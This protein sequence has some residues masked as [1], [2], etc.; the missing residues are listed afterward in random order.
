MAYDIQLR[1]PERWLSE[2]DTF[3]D[4]SG[5]LVTHFEAT[6]PAGKPDEVRAFVDIYVGDMPEDET[7][8]D[9]AFANYAET[10]GF[11]EDDPE[12]FNPIFKTKFNG[13]NAWGF[14]AL[15]ENETPMRFLAQE[16]RKGV[17]A[18]IVFGALN[19]AG[20]VSL[21]ETLERNLRVR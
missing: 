14:D 15:C 6:L 20:L 17:L 10:V 16:V 13:K 11:S 18:I 12:D 7:A 9:Q 5:V 2:C 19:E 21:Q 1:L 4:E 3:E 8:E